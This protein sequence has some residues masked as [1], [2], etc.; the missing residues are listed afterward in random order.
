MNIKTLMLIGLSATLFVGCDSRIDEVNLKMAEIRS[1]PPL[2]IEPTPI[3][4]PAPI[5]NYS[6]LQ[7]RSPFIQ[8]SLAAEL[9][10]MAGKQVFPNLS[11]QPQPLESYPLESLSFKGSLKNN[12]DKIIALIHTPDGDI[13]RVQVG[14]YMGMS[15]GRVV[16][17]TPTQLDLVEIIPDGRDGFV[18]RPRS[19]ILIG[20]M[21]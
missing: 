18:E 2:A 3:F 10:L 21:P 7:L 12:A 15:Y 13:E 14:S 11:R 9:K 16:K 1:Q 17:I 8:N 6:A 5:F 19:L 4:E 20:L